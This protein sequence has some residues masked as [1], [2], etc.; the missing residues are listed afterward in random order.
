M[1]LK[2]NRNSAKFLKGGR[3]CPPTPDAMDNSDYD[4]VFGEEEAVPIMDSFDSYIVV[5]VLTA[6][7]SF[8][9]LYDATLDDN[10]YRLYPIVHTIWVTICTIS[11]MSGMYA[12][13]V[14]SFS[15]TYG[16]TAAGTGRLRIYETF[17]ESTAEY[18][19]RAFNMYLL[20]LWSFVALLVMTAAERVESR[21]RGAFIVF[22]L[23]AS[24][25]MYQDWNAVMKAAT[26]IFAEEKIQKEYKIKRRPLPVGN[27][28][29][30]RD[31]IN[32]QRMNG[33]GNSFGE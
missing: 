4:E 25:W 6:T 8:A 29:L 33:I 27:R 17:L 15:S 14:F 9:A 23:V 11:A 5:S 28:S 24:V 2:S 30:Y 26:P 22:L 21:F 10:S 12:T 19:Q 7:A 18:R 20:S 3:S 13:V 32:V 16:H 31:S 1:S